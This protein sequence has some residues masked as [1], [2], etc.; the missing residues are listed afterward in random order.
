MDSIAASDEILFVWST[1]A[2]DKVEEVVNQIKE[3]SGGRAPAVENLDRLKL[4]MA[5]FMYP[6]LMP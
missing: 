1:T 4:G 3:H 6:R 5:L 2:S